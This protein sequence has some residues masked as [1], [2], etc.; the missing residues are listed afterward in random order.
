MMKRLT[1]L[2]L[3]L[4]LL[5][6][7][8]GCVRQPVVRRPDDGRPGNT[9]R[10]EPPRAPD[11]SDAQEPDAPEEPEDAGDAENAE[12]AGGAVQT[13]DLLGFWEGDIYSNRALGLSFTLPEDWVP[14]SDEELL[15]MIN[16]ILDS[17]IV[18][19]RGKMLAQFKKSSVIFGMVA[20]E[21]NGDFV[22]IMFESLE[23]QIGKDMITEERY[24][25]MMA[26][27]WDIL[28][29]SGGET[30]DLGETYWTQLG[31]EDFLVLPADV[32]EYKQ[33]MYLRRVDD[34]MAAIVFTTYSDED[35]ETMTGGASAFAPLD[36]SLYGAG[37][38]G[39]S[40]GTGTS[41][42][43]GTSG[44]LTAAGDIGRTFDTMFF[45]YT[46]LS[47]ENPAEYDGY[48]PEDGNQL[49]VVRVRVKNDFGSTLPMYDTDFPLFWGNGDSDFSWAVDAFNK[50]MM[51]LEWEL[52]N[53][54][55]A[56][57]DMLFEAP[58]DKTEF[59]L[60]YLEEYTD[61]A[62]RERTGEWYDAYFTLLRP[63]A[64]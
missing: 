17:D 29:E 16:I 14:A 55:E 59:S 56:V 27:Q 46:V 2:F 64:A 28:I 40:G 35:V 44:V 30:R 10:P 6:S 48:T 62:G 23:N 34:W 52:A 8:A 43:T 53:G 22:Q 25:E 7:L 47:V 38:N 63:S 18:N 61:K 20:S 37:S 26:A 51:P 9:G 36:E 31:G 13:E 41:G 15:G 33:W 60:S 5:C 1:A 24:V 21:P 49:I 11:G 54:E 32:I 57:Y 58:A 39:V 3:A 19:D 45:D 12:D 4:V 50:N 42:S